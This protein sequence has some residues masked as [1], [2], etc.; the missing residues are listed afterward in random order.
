M[1]IYINDIKKFLEEQFSDLSRQFDW[2]NSGGQILSSGSEIRKIGFALDPSKQVIAQAIN[3]GCELLITHHPL[4]FAPLKQIDTATLLGS[5][6]NMA[7]KNNLNILSY[8][9]SLDLADYSLNDY[10]ADLVDAE[11]EDFL[12]YF[13]SDGY[14]KFVCF[15]PRGY[16]N[17]IID[18]IDSAGGGCIGRYSK[19]TFFVEGTGTF[20]PGDSANPFIGKKGEL[21]KTEEYR[22]ETIVLK[23]DIDNV[24]QSAAKVHPYE[25]MA[26]DVYPMDL[27]K[28]NG[29]GRV[30]S[31]SEKILF[32]DFLTKLEKILN[33]D[34]LRH[35][36]YNLD[37]DFKKFAIVTGSGASLWKRC[38]QK[39]VKVLLTGDLKHHEALDAAEAGVTI[40]DCGHFNT[41]R[42]YMEY[43]SSIIQKNFA[44]DTIMLEEKPSIKYFW[45]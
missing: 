38:V 24:I 22:L 9:T 34:I 42:I 2:D 8:H 30:C 20:L 7:L 25:E 15:V 10:L 21:T 14:V 35:N 11:T 36:A 26:Y 31:F 18:A 39:D 1:P 45:G 40:V 16:E 33:L 44:I 41:E 12:E 3:E 32:K 27:E 4:F 29:L 28:S 13:N 17:S 5:K 43:L 6:I 19:C 37:F 23:K